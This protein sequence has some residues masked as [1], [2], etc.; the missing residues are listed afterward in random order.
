MMPTTEEL[1]ESAEWEE[2]IQAYLAC[3]AFVDAQVGKVLQALETSTYADNTIVVL[4]ADHGYHL[5]EKNRFAK[6]AL[7]ERN[8]R[9]VLIFNNAKG[10][11][12]QICSAP[13][14]L[15]D[16]YPTLIDLCNLPSFELL[17]GHS[18][19]SLIQNPDPK[20]QDILIQDY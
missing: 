13:V 4:W 20:E 8:T 7:W 3:I 14:Q 2:A 9:T 15:I 19:A 1:L 5:G 17:E 16:I 11:A 10:K 18:L 12:K 6:Q